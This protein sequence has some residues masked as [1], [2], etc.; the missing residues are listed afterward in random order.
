[1][2]P[3]KSALG[4]H[5]KVS[6][7]GETVIR[8]GTRVQICFFGGRSFDF[9]DI[10]IQSFPIVVGRHINATYEDIGNTRKG[11]LSENHM[12]MKSLQ[13]NIQERVT[14]K[15][16]IL[17]SLLISISLDS[18]VASVISCSETSPSNGFKSGSLKI[19]NCS[20]DMSRLAWPSFKQ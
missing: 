5:S 19:D 17:S 7:R 10:Q 15:I 9:V 20:L 6:L 3:R 13:S 1:M 4:I 18:G 16:S 8:G 11:N 12:K 2:C 14:R